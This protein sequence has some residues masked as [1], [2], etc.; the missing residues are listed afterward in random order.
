MRK[1][2]Q[3]LGLPKPFGTSINSK[4]TTGFSNRSPPGCRTIP[5]ATAAAARRRSLKTPR[6]CR[7]PW[8]IACRISGEPALSILARLSATRCPAF[9]RV[10][11]LK[12]KGVAA[13]VAGEWI[14]GA[15]APAA[16]GHRLALLEAGIAAAACSSRDVGTAIVGP[17]VRA[18]RRRRCRHRN[19]SQRDQRRGRDGQFHKLFHLCLSVSFLNCRSWWQPQA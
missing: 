5:R 2:F 10:L 9:C 11:G 14:R 7:D 15:I 4:L 18:R 6:R 16:G 17:V 19:K 1:V 3:F 13:G 12:G 8:S